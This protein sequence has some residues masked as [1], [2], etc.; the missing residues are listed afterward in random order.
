MGLGRRP[1]CVAQPLF[2]N[3]SWAF[4]SASGWTGRTFWRDKSRRPSTRGRL[5]GG[6]G[7]AERRPPLGLRVGRGGAGPVLLARRVEAPEPPRQAGGVEGLAE[8][9]VGPAAQVG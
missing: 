5:G 6:G 8:A 9:R 7:L 3:R 2:A 4:G 1:Q